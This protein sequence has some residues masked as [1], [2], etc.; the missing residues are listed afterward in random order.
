MF[1]RR[2]I[3][4]HLFHRRDLKALLRSSSDT[5]SLWP[6]KVAVSLV[7]RGQ[8]HSTPTFADAIDI[9]KHYA[10]DL[11]RANKHKF[12]SEW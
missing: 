11:I 7:S 8:F 4:S 12:S 6:P 2:G 10:G 3:R 5:R 9:Q 1:L